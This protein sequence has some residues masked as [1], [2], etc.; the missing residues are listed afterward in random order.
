M[1]VITIIFILILIPILCLCMGIGG[2]VLYR[3]SNNRYIE[4]LPASIYK[5]TSSGRFHIKISTEPKTPQDYV[6]RGSTDHL[7]TKKTIEIYRDDTNRLIFDDWGECDSKVSTSCDFY[8]YEFTLN[9]KYYLL[10]LI[11]VFGRKGEESIQLYDLSDEKGISITY[12][13]QA[14]CFG[15][16]INNKG[17]EFKAKENSCAGIFPS[18][19]Y[20]IEL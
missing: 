13:A 8:Y 12:H 2:Y 5:T 3:E 7:D 10:Y 20:T 6:N 18:N 4:F 9:G 19:P 15:L 11:N 14:D 16:R 1:R 17:I